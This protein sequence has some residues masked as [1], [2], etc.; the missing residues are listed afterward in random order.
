MFRPTL[1][2]T[3]LTVAVAAGLVA[4]GE[5]D[6]VQVDDPTI[7]Q[8]AEQAGSFTTLLTAVEAAGLTATLESDGPFTVFAPSDDAFAKLPEDA[9]DALLADVDLLTQVL[10]YHVVPGAVTAA[11]VVDLSSAPTVNGKALSISVTDGTVMVGGAKVVTTDIQARNGI[12]HV[13]DDALLPVPVL[14]LVQTAR[15]A[16]SFSTLLAALD[17]TSLTSVL[18]GNGPFTVFA[19]TDDA[20]AALPEGTLEAL[21]ADPEALAGILTYHVVP[22][23]VTSDQVVNLSSAT[24]VNGAD[25]AI[26][27]NGG[28]VSVNDA[29][30][31]A[32]DVAA[33]NGVIHVIDKVILPPM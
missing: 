18:K 19:P 14:D 22:G 12:I 27:V 29:T 10:T 7:I 17:A 2:R 25:I 31:I 3:G 20:F 32:V 1:F 23:N 33:T 16:G 8:V 26:S 9:L 24:T 28:T 13:V 30:V 15:K 6:P 21:L 4:C 5:D 11:Q